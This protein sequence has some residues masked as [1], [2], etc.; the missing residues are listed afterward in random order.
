MRARA[1]FAGIVGALL[2]VVVGPAVAKVG[3]V[4]ARIDGPGLGG[5]GLRILPPGTEELWES[6]LDWAGGLDDAK[7]DSIAELGLMA[8]ELGSKYVVTY[9]LDAGTEAAEIVRQ[10]LYPYA[11]GGPVTH[12]PPGQV[13]AEGRPWE[14]AVTA[15]WHRSSPGSFQFLL[16]QGLPASDPVIVTDRETAPVPVPALAPAFWGWIPAALAGLAAVS[17]AATRLRRR[18]EPVEGD[19]S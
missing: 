17:V 14:G 15:G 1:S 8:S 9:R 18:S 19:V 4:E 7:I 11:K 12:T 3:I 10:E 16:D 13:I 2:L 5:A 6:G